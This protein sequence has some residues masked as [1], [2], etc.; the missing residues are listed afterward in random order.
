MTLREQFEKEHKNIPKREFPMF[1]SIKYIQ[2]L[3]KR[4]NKM[5][6]RENCKYFRQQI[7]GT[8]STCNKFEQWELKE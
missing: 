6:N 5:K 2:W 3:E 7:I 8:C 1:L 4:I